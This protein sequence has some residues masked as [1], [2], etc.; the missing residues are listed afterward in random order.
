[1]YRLPKGR[2]KMPRRT[3]LEISDIPYQYKNKILRINKSYCEPNFKSSTILTDDAFTY[4]EFYF[5]SQKKAMKYANSAS[6]AK[7]GDE[8]KYHYSFYWKQALEFYRA[9][10]LLTLESA[11]LLSYYSMLNAAKAFLAFKCEY[12]EEFI[13][14]FGNHGLFERND[15]DGIDLNTIAVWRKNKGVF[16][17]LGRKIE[18]NF[19][20][21]WPSGKSNAITLKNLLYNLAYVHRSYIITYNTARKPAVPELFIPLKA[22]CA[23]AYHNGNDSNL[24]LMFEVDRSFFPT[25]ATSIPTSYLSSISNDFCVRRNNN[26]ALRS[27]SGGKR[28][29]SDS[30]SAEFKALNS[31]LR[32]EFQYIRSNRRLWYLKRSNLVH[33][34]VINLNSMLIT[35]AAMH[36]I[37]EI[38]RYK[39]EQLAHLMNSKEN[40][41]IHEFLTLA[42]DQFI[43]EIAAEIT[44][45]EIMGTG[46][47]A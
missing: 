12:I 36:R 23:P 40:W 25:T 19:D 42:L 34:D 38:V 32:R 22:D 15:L 3:E 30:L 39:P 20:S 28:N 47:K 27:S 44:G 1:M 29:T 9:S 8:K 46:T 14:H 35:M 7:Y 33:S 6:K 43:D 26:F 4:I 37:S 5:A 41:L 24:Y 21:I 2:E 13:E 18:S 10:K 31:K 17:L 11:P 45:Q 16:P